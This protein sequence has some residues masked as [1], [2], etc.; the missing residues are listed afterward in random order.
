MESQI[1]CLFTTLVQS[2]IFKK[3]ESTHEWSPNLL[4]APRG[5]H[6]WVWAWLDTKIPFL[7]SLLSTNY[8]L[9]TPR[10]KSATNEDDRENFQIT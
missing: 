3:N 2:I 10:N 5:L 7:L 8:E 9:T 6:G 4:P 1:P